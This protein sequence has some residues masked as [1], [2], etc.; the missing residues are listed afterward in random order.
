MKRVVSESEK[1][2]IGRKNIAGEVLQQLK[3]FSSTKNLERTTNGLGKP[4]RKNLI[5]KNK[6]QSQIAAR[7]QKI[8][9][10]FCSNTSVL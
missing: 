10:I 1:S 6:N 8:R 5:M 3:E 4:F 9:S 7:E 2:Q